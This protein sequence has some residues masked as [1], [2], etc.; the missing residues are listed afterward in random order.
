MRRTLCLALCLTLSGCAFFRDVGETLEGLTNPLV[1]LGML[2]AVEPPSTDEVDLS[3]TD[4][5]DGTAFTVFLAD[6][7]QVDEIEEAPVLGAQVVLQDVEAVETGG[8]SYT[9]APGALDYAAGSTWTAEIHLGG[10]V[11]TADVPLPE[12]VDWE[13]PASHPAGADLEVTTTGDYDSLLVVV[14]A[15]DG[16]VTW[17]NRPETP[18]EIYDF[19][20][21]SDDDLSVTI[22]GDE[23]FVEEDL[24]FVGAAG[25]VHTG[26]S[27]L[28]GMNTA[29][30]TLMSGKMVLQPVSTLTA[31]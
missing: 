5:E 1:S 26:S 29:L 25:M 22:P 21:G 3:G 16:S 8:G 23:A 12:P 6:A 9:V 7:A 14:L 4:Y 20:H 17:D 18:R 31:P 28:S 15:S 27:D 10:D 11:A 30:S 13:A 2:L 24:Y 19:T